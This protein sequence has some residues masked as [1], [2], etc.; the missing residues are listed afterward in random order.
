MK[1]F[2]VASILLVVMLLCMILP[3]GVSAEDE[4]TTTTTTTTTPAPTTTTTTT[5]TTTT[6]TTTTPPPEMSLK[7]TTSFPKIEVVSGSS[8]QFSVS[9]VY[10]NTYEGAKPAEFDLVVIVPNNWTGYVN[11]SSG[12]RIASI[13]LDPSLAYGSSV[14]VYATPPTY[15]PPEPGEYKVTLQATSADIKNTI[16]LTV[17]VTAQYSL[18]LVPTGTTPVYSTSATAGKEKIY[19]VT[20]KNNGTDSIDN[21]S[22]TSSVPTLSFKH[23]SFNLA[24]IRLSN[25]LTSFPTWQLC[26]R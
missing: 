19:S 4:T 6:T 15:L 16:D 21:I 26:L 25:D 24:S 22:L 1:W 23:S 10:K 7:M 14:T 13:N 12:T 5:E 20:I 9:L 3:I 11:S 8:V 17:L 2:R 18:S